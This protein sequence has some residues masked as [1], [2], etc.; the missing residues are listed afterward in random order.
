MVK[1]KNTMKTI[2]VKNNKNIVDYNELSKAV[3][4]LNQERI[5]DICQGFVDRHVDE[6]IE[7]V[8]MKAIRDGVNRVTK[9]YENGEYNIK[10]IIDMRDILDKVMKII[11]ARV[12]PLPK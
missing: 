4:N 9:K 2:G 11:A 12:E 7:E 6:N 8:F 1:E 5:I 10:H 3:E